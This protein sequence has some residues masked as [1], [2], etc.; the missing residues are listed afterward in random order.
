MDDTANL[1]RGEW[2][3]LQGRM[4]R[5][6]I[7]LAAQA[8]SQ[9]LSFLLVSSVVAHGALREKELAAFSQGQAVMWMLGA[10]GQ[11]LVTTCM[12]YGLSRTGLAN[13]NRLNRRLMGAAALLELL[14]CLPPLDGLVFRGFLGLKGAMA[15]VARNS[16]L[17]SLPLQC[18][19]FLRNP[20]LA[21]LLVE[22]RSG[23]ANLATMARI[24]LAMAIAPPMIRLGLTGHAWG[25]VAITL[26]VA[27]EAWL[28]R[29]FAL[30]GMRALT[31]EE[32]AEKASVAE[33]LRFTI[34]LSFGGVMIAGTTMGTA[35]FLGH[36]S[37]AAAALPVHYVVTGL[38]NPVSFSALR[39]QSV[40]IAFPPK[41]AG[42]APAAFAA[43]VG[44]ALCAVLLVPQ[45]PA[46]SFWYFTGVQNLPP[47]LVG[48]ARTAL[49]IA[50]P[51]PLLQAFKGHG[52]GQAAVRR[53]PNAILVDQATY[54]AVY[55]GTIAT[56]TTG[57]L[58][59]GAVTGLLGIT[60]AIAL[61]LAALRAAL[62]A[63]DYER[64]LGDG[65]FGTAA[66]RSRR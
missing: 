29:H 25:A 56:V 50:A 8:A 49:L 53:R 19:F 26:P 13:F 20:Y 14:C 54:A 31:D 4:L 5:F 7:P 48:L 9:S 34:P 38:V 22:K 55:V 33:Q 51:I 52:E 11:G 3:R 21:R 28:T 47:E 41:E 16:L 2:W 36:A 43:M 12:V 46:L 63:N 18:L 35:F 1:D 65:H 15:V 40:T 30:P 32:G 27:L 57:H 42:R 23:A 61:S 17:F 10:I 60:L 64:H 66:L 6:F 44:A 62:I 59:P 37:D 45:I 58:L 24:A 39:M